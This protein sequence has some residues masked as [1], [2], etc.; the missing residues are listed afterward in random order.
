MSVPF[1][2]SETRQNLMRAFAG[3]C[4]ARTRYTF[5]AGLAKSRELPVIQSLLLLTAEQE[6]EHAER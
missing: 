2:R 4:Q 5:A 3:E 6:K 1:E